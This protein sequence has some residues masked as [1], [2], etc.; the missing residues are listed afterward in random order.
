[1][2]CLVP[3]AG[4]DF[5]DP[6]RGVKALTP[7]DGLPL[8]RRAIESRPWWRAGQLTSD[9]LVFVLR[10]TPQTAAFRAQLAGWYP[11]CRF[12]TVSDLTA[13]AL[14][15]ALAGIALARDWTAPLMIDLVDILFDLDE[16]IV[17]AFA[18]TAD[19]GAVAPVFASSDPAYS[20]LELDAAGRVTRAAEKQLISSHASAGCY[21]FRDVPTFL[22]AAA[23][24]LRHAGALAFR[25]ALF[26]CPALNG[27]IAG[28]R[29]VAVAPAR[30]VV[31]LS[32]MFHS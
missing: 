9:G 4:P 26:V 13:G 16:D 15:S 30:D 21:L 5:H 12:A 10:D 31:P 29:A 23:H 22:E 2:I 6:Q 27:V 8:V 17:G 19:L 25:D 28:G 11:G 32:K 1:M 7:V 20:Y 24:S 18:W 3:L 14:L